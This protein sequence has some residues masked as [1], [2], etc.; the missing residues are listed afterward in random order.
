MDFTARGTLL[1][2]LYKPFKN[3]FLVRE[4][5]IEIFIQQGGSLCITASAFS[6]AVK[7]F[8]SFFTHVKLNQ[9][10]TPFDV[11]ELNLQTACSFKIHVE[12]IAHPRLYLELTL[13]VAHKSEHLIAPKQ[14]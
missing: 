6:G 13:S 10:S 11:F 7:E 1:C 3:F 12:L 2:H 9:A 5:Y 14:M 8:R 4:H